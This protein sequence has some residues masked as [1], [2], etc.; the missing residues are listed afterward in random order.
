[1]II[2]NKKELFELSMLEEFGI[3]PAA[4]G[5]LV[6]GA[7]ASVAGSVVLIGG[8]LAL[9]RTISDSVS[10]S[11]PQAIQNVKSRSKCNYRKINFL[12]SKLNFQKRMSGI[13][14]HEREKQEIM[15]KVLGWIEAKRNHNL[16][17]KT[18][19]LVLYLVGS[20]GVGKTMAAEAVAA[21]LLGNGAKAP[22]TVSLSSIDTAS[23]ASTAEQ[24]FGVVEETVNGNLKIKKVS[25]LLNQIKRNPKTVIIINE[26]DKLQKRDGSLDNCLWDIADNGMIDINGEKIDCSQAVIIATSNEAPS[27]VGKKDSFVDDGSTTYIVHNKAFI[28]RI[29][30]I[31]FDSLSEKEY[32]I[33]FN[34]RLKEVVN[35]YKEKYK[36]NINMSKS[37]ID[38][39]VKDIVKANRGAREANAYINNLY[40]QLVSYRI[41]HKIADC[42]GKANKKTKAI[43]LVVSYN[44]EN[45]KF[46]IK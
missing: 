23:S 3:T 6:A 33:I 20:S 7:L 22:M 37:E 42:K 18:G 45:Q 24:L 4:V 43:E 40:A 15:N 25:P 21:E 30:P 39:V 36:L 11:I 29:N 32:E 41:N 2:T 16:T 27:C 14:G 46:C 17:N 44:S 34:T 5:G 38:K 31:V 26:Y 28:N 13:I 35:D 10:K 12:P 1:M 8:G 9:I 19:G